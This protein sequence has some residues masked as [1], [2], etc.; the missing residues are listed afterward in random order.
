MDEGGEVGGE[1][2]EAEQEGGEDI[3]DLLGTTAEIHITPP[4]RRRHGY[5][6][7]PAQEEGPHRPAQLA[8]KIRRSRALCRKTTRGESL[9]SPIEKADDE[10]ML[11]DAL[12]FTFKLKKESKNETTGR[13]A[14]GG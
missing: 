9:R 13:S 2:A 14:S 11:A 7:P 8:L 10:G 1:E 3:K 12:G 4:P 6:S 5:L